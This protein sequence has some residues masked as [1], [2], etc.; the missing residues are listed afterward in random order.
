MTI[1]ITLGG[2]PVHDALEEAANLQRLGY[3]LP[4]NFQRVN[5]LCNPRGREPARGWFLLL[6]Q[7]LQQLDLN[8]LLT[9][10]MADDLGNSASVSGLVIAREPACITPSG[11]AG[12]PDA[13]YL[14]EV[15]DARWRC[16]NPY[17]SIPVTKQ[18]NL[19]ASGWGGQYYAASLKAGSPWSWEK[20]LADLW[21]AVS[22]QLGAAPSLPVSPDGIP[23]RYQ[24]LG[25]SCWLAICQVLDKLGCAVAWNAPA[26]SYT[27]AALGA[28]DSATNATLTRA[29]NRLLFD[30]QLRA[31]VRGRVPAGVR[32][33]FHRIQEHYGTEPATEQDTTQFITDSVYTVDV[34]G[35]A[36]V[37]G[38]AEGGT[39]HPLWDDLPA[40]YDAAGSLQNGPA[41]ATRAQARANAYYAMIQGSGG[42]RL[43]QVY[44]G[45]VKVMPGATLAGVIWRQDLSGLG[46]P[47][48]PGGLIT[49]VIRTP[50]THL[51]VTDE[52]Q[53]ADIL[54]DSTAL[55]PPDYRVKEPAYPDLCQ[56]VR[57]NSD[58]GAEEQYDDAT[59]QRWD[60][61]AQEWL[62]K[63]PVWLTD[64]N[65]EPDSSEP[66]LVGRLV[67]FTNGRPVYAAAG[68]TVQTPDGLVKARHV[69]V[70]EIGDNLTL[71]DLGGGKVRIDD[72]EASSSSSTSGGYTGLRTMPYTVECDPLGGLTVTYVTEQWQDGRLISWG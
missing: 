21:D 2:Y 22:G 30:R 20:M 60:P 36:G 44:A 59:L 63:E 50:G 1:E 32:V 11:D 66:A 55:H 34:P 52:G 3:P 69:H 17:Y 18:Y 46:D 8:G 65:E 6:R 37:T 35:P 5:S 42:S 23:E 47:D 67:G 39:F 53:L 51:R 12:D 41:L 26:G 28:A 62:T 4:E 71:I 43:H 7:H 68:L 31:V 49:E 40:I 57:L 38:G 9:L 58:P 13:C 16:H 70:I 72:E 54:P 29:G 48:N 33:H 24:F 61:D 56:L 64:P 10:T 15:A 27:I 14:V 19:R 45:L 25:V